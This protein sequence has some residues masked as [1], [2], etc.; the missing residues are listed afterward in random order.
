MF[1]SLVKGQKQ[2]GDVGKDIEVGLTGTLEEMQERGEL[3]LWR[4][5][6]LKI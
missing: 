2:V 5:F 4:Y 3:Q 6:N 1:Y